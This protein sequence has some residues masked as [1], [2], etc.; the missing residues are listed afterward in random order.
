MDYDV[1]QSELYHQAKDKALS[2]GYQV[3]TDAYWAF[4]RG[5]MTAVEELVEVKSNKAV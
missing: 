5:Y 2:L 3:N 1:T 4:L